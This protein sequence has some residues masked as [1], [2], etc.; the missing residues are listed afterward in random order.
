MEGTAETAFTCSVR[1]NVIFH[2]VQAPEFRVTRA[3]KKI[4]GI[5]R[6][7]SQVSKVVNMWSESE[8]FNVQCMYNT[9]AHF[10]TQVILT[11]W[12]IGEARGVNKNLD[13]PIHINIIIRNVEIA[14]PH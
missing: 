14:S 1:G 7:K 8:E 10:T 4:H 9:H 6:K 5:I 12:E 2:F 13:I 11:I 3:E